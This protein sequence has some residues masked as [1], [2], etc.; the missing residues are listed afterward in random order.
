MKTGF[1]AGADTYDERIAGAG[2]HWTVDQTI[3]AAQSVLPVRGAVL[4]IGCG[5]GLYTRALSSALAGV[6]GVDFSFPM[7]KAATR[8]MPRRYVCADCAR[9]LPF[10]DA[11]FDCVTAFDVLAYVLDLDGLFAE[12][13]RVMKPGG[14]FYAVVP[15]A[16][17]LVRRVARAARLGGYAAG[18]PRERHAFHKKG[19][20]AI[21]R[22]MFVTCGVRVI[23]PVPG[24]A[25]G[26]YTQA[27]SLLKP[28]FSCE[29]IGLGLLAWGRKA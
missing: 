8:A 4:D 11:T 13:K 12:V 24:F 27:P 25:S 26:A 28:L 10:P 19:L 6:V 7:L 9:P 5:T 15:N 16:Q 1:D 21:M 20:L 2:R 17:S 3:K 22:R 29:L 18:G 14:V 23:R